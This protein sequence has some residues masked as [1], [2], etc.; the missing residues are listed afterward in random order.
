MSA[1]LDHKLDSS[2]L[3]VTAGWL[4]IGLDP[5]QENIDLDTTH[6]TGHP[7][8]D[9]GSAPGGLGAGRTEMESV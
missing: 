7:D 2:T 9:T 6:L 4:Q 5:V 1:L 3:T 8:R